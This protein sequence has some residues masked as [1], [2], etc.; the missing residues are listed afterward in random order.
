MEDT[1][2][3]EQHCDQ[4]A[5]EFD[6]WA[7]GVKCR[8]PIEPGEVLEVTELEYDQIQ[9]LLEKGPSQ[10]LIEFLQTPSVFDKA[11]DTPVQRKG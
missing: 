9:A 6:C 2:Q 10:K 11:A 1:A 4:C 7:T 3:N 5:P 8:K